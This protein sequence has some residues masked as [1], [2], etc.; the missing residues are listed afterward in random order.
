[1]ENVPDIT[2]AYPVAFSFYLLYFTQHFQVFYNRGVLDYIVGNLFFLFSHS[3]Q[4]I[5]VFNDC[6]LVRY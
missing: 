5:E 4:H 2:L 1:M 3:S 6:L